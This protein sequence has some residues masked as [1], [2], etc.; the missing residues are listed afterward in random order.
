MR[1]FANGL[2]VLVLAV[3]LATPS[4]FA[5][6]RRDDGDV[7]RSPLKKIVQVIKRIVKGLDGTD[8][9]VPKP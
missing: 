4:A 5:A 9:S 8:M 2:F 6:P 3:S 1:R 7:Y